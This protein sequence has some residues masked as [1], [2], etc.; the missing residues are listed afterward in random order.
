MRM[1]VVSLNAC[2]HPNKVLNGLQ[3]AMVSG[4]EQG[5]YLSLCGQFT[6][7]HFGKKKVY[8]RIVMCPQSISE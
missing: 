8:N 4:C 5:F 3:M 6:I 1:L 7:L 2:S